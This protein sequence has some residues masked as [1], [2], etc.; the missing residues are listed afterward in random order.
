MNATRFFLGIGLA[1]LALGYWNPSLSRE[2]KDC[3]AG[4]QG[5]EEISCVATALKVG[6]KSLC[7]VAQ[8]VSN[9]NLLPVQDPTG[10]LREFASSSDE[11]RTSVDAKSLETTCAW[12]P[13]S[14]KLRAIEWPC[15]CGS[16]NWRIA[17]LVFA[18]ASVT[19][20]AIFAHLV[21]T[22]KLWK[23]SLKEN[24]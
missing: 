8:P 24:V 5:L 22:S 1:F 13:V 15:D 18:S 12:E 16:R 3:A 4:C 17:C 14:K 10:C 19:L 20:A 9:G 2:S 7:W 23:S 21:E 6:R 11:S